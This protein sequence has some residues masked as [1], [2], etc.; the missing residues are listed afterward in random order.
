MSFRGLL[1]HLC[2]STATQR[3]SHFWNQNTCCEHTISSGCHDT[4]KRQGTLVPPLHRW[5]E[6]G[7]EQAGNLLGHL[8]H[9]WVDPQFLDLINELQ[10]SPVSN[11]S[12]VVAEK[13]GKPVYT[14]WRP[15][16]LGFIAFWWVPR[17][18][19]VA[20]WGER[21]ILVS[22]LTGSEWSL[23]IKHV[24]LLPWA[25]VLPLVEKARLQ[26]PSPLKFW[27]TWSITCIHSKC[28]TI[29]P[30]TQ[31]KTMT[32]KKMGTIFNSTFVLK[33]FLNTSKREWTIRVL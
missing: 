32:K 28:V 9:L 11:H 4:P 20:K 31:F 8:S 21:N 18:S 15:Q 14:R 25:S 22:S 29:L 24:A 27:K 19:V 30:V 26:N 3:S 33:Q 16:Q 17:D 12:T 7:Q 2:S 5:G 10:G 23:G 6:W 13:T 1:Y